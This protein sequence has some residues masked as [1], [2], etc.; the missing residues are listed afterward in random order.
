MS[1]MELVPGDDANGED[2]DADGEDEDEDGED[3]EGK[4][5]AEV[6]QAMTRTRG[7]RA[8]QRD[9]EGASIERR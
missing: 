7:A 2:E 3:G 9:G 8:M 6:K 1:G 4:A 5:T